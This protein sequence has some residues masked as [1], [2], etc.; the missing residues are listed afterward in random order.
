[1]FAQEIPIGTWRMHLPYATSTDLAFMGDRVASSTAFSLM[2]YFPGDG[3]IQTLDEANALNDFGVQK[4]AYHSER[5]VLVIAYNNG[6]IDLIE[7]GNKVVS[8]T[9]ILNSNEPEVRINH[10][11]FLGEQALLS[12]NLGILVIDLEA[13]EVKDTYRIGSNG[14]NSE[15]FQVDTFENRFYAAC[16]QGLKSADINNPFLGNFNNWRQAFTQSIEF[17]SNYA[18]SLFVI[19]NDSL[20]AF[21]GAVWEVR[22]FDPFWTTQDMRADAN[23]LHLSQWKDS[24]NSIVSSRIMTIESGAVQFRGT[25]GLIRPLAAYDDGTNLWVSDLFQ[26]LMRI[27]SSGIFSLVANSPR[28]NSSFAVEATDNGV[29]I[30]AGGTTDAFGATFNSNGF[31][32]FQDQFWSSY[33][34]FFNPE[35]V[36]VF[37]LIDAYTDPVS[38]KTYLSSLLSGLVE[39][40][41]GSITIYE[42]NNSILEGALADTTRTK[43]SDV[44]GDDDGDIYIA[45]FGAQNPVAVLMSDGSWTNFP[46]IQ[47]QR[48]ITEF[49]IDRN[50]QKWFAIQGNGLVVLDDNDDPTNPSAFVQRK[51]GS[52]AGNGNLHNQRIYALAEDNDGEIWVGTEKGIAIYY[53]SRSVL[54]SNGCD[55][56]R[57]IVTRDGVN[58]YLFETDKVQAIAVDGANRK[59]IGT[60]DGLFLIS[61]DGEQEIFAFTTENS[62]LPSN[63]IFDIGIVP[64]TG[65]VFIATDQGLVSYRSDATAG[66]PT[67]TNNVLVFPNP[68][69]P[70]YEGPI[71]IQGLVDGAYI[72]ITDVQGTLIFEGPANG[73][74][75]IWNGRDYNGDKAR[76]GVYL[77]FSSNEAGDENHVAKILILN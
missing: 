73:G 7:G 44:E 65:E 51:L 53:C 50:G 67:Q 49:I 45:N 17:V 68:V 63:N 62:P 42:K 22:R 56:S 21:G 28:Y 59:W 24:A 10:I 57:P 38:G 48:D 6:N 77:V 11:F 18:D 27:N 39:F 46:L 69:Q 76:S 9:D 37:D 3:S 12:S 14:T 31:Y 16:D 75:A 26:G 72:K 19:H 34:L 40:D 58:G 41:N 8:F 4:I 13:L 33:N 25:T 47:N 71:A 74:T 61:D 23:G 15:V 64:S 20:K 35:L 55:A 43:I 32:R 2:Y 29:F 54:T 5:D 70:E 36:G 60:P 52:G 1:M 66:S 30:A